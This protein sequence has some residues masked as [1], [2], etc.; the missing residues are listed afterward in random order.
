MLKSSKLK[1]VCG[2][3][4][5]TTAGTVCAQWSITGVH[6]DLSLYASASEP[7]TNIVVDQ[8]SIADHSLN[9]QGMIEVDAQ[10]G[11]FTSIQAMLSQESSLVGNTLSAS[12]MRGLGFSANSSSSGGANTDSSVQFDIRIDAAVD[13]ELVYDVTGVVPFGFV[14]PIQL[15]GTPDGGVPGNVLYHEAGNGVDTGTLQP[16]NYSLSVT[17]NSEALDFFDTFN[18][19]TQPYAEQDVWSF[20][21]TLVPAPA[22]GTL[23]VAGGLFAARR[24]R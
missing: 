21:F 14:S 11:G 5:S 7:G 22:T 3:A 12:S 4:I 13:F 20:Q 17:S 15:Y 8:D 10:S 1:L 24:R 9:F 18:P 16:G 23:L 19:D 2:M 6:R